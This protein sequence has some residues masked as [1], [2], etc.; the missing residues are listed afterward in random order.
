MIRPVLLVL[1]FSVTAFVVVDH[2]FVAVFVVLFLLVAVARGMQL[3]SKID[4][5][6]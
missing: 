2:G 6:S 3:G 4:R 1:R 5:I